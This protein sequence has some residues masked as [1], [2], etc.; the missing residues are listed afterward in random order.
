MFVILALLA[1]YWEDFSNRISIRN[2]KRSNRFYL[3]LLSRLRRGKHCTPP[4]H[5]GQKQKMTRNYGQILSC[6]LKTS[7]SRSVII[8]QIR[9]SGFPY[10]KP[11]NRW[12]LLLSV[13]HIFHFLVVPWSEF[14][15]FS[16][17]SV[18]VAVILF[19]YFWVKRYLKKSSIFW[20]EWC[21][22]F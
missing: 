20:D 9:I 3:F 22:K 14:F 21:T 1:A 17:P 4:S 10:R 13:S 7:I 5:F 8:L 2:E 16:L 15:F 18:K 19:P 12:F 6:P 11:F